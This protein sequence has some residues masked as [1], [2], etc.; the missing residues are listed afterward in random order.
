MSEVDA[1]LKKLLH[2]YYTHVYPSCFFLQPPL[3]PKSP[4]VREPLLRQRLCVLYTVPKYI[5]AYGGGQGRAYI[6]K[7]FSFSAGSARPK[8]LPAKKS[9]V[10]IASV[11]T[12][13]LVPA[14]LIFVSVKKK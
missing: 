1:A 7:A 11:G 6:S 8:R 10:E 14:M 5:T 4:P 12:I 2:A 3:P 13:A 9:A